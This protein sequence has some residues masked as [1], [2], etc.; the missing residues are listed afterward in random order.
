[1]LCNQD[2][3]NHSIIVYKMLKLR[4][5]SMTRWYYVHKIVLNKKALN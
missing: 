2:I 5:A 4:I 3:F 1:M